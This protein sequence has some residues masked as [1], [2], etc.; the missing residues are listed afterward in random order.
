MKCIATSPPPPKNK[1]FLNRPVVSLILSSNPRISM[2]LRTWERY[3][4]ALLLIRMRCDQNTDNS[5]ADVNKK[6]FMSNC[7]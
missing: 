1:L 6:C 3:S 4:V 2:L 5:E 7:Q